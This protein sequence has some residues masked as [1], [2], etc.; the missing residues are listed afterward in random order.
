MP[1]ATRPSRQ[2]GTLLLSIALAACGG[3][4]EGG[5]DGSEKF[6]KAKDGGSAGSAGSDGT[7]TTIDLGANPCEPT[8]CEELGVD[9]GK[10]ADGCGEI[11]DCGGCADGALCGILDANTCTVLADLCEPLSERDACAGKQCGFAGDGC[12]GIYD[13]GG[14]TGGET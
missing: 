14:C 3:N 12:D 7:G 5:G 6:G 1:F 8:T 10:I 13:C 4:P 2:L 11:L 9:C